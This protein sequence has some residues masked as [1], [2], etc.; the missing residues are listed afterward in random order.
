MQAGVLSVAAVV[1]LVDVE[2]QAQLAIREELTS[3]SDVI[4]SIS[5]EYPL[6]G[7]SI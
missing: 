5:K 3:E 6:V 1:T 7:E 2:V 4:D